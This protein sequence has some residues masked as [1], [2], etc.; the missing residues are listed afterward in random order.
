VD[1]IRYKEVDFQFARSSGPGGQ[2]VNKRETKV[3]LSR[4]IMKSKTLP[5]PYRQRCIDANHT[6][7]TDE[8][9][10]RLDAQ[11]HRTQESNKELLQKKLSNL[12]KD[13]FKEPKVRKISET[14]KH[15]VDRRIAEKKRRS[16]IRASRTV[17][18]NFI[19]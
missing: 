12:I 6:I 19:A 16:K 8:G 4:D 13:A 14:P 1:T 17:I 3:Q 11:V 18:T 15:V 5:E 9:I 2:N 7:I 10:L